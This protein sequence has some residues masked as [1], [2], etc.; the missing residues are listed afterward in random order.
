MK[1]KNSSAKI[2]ALFDLAPDSR[3]SLSNCLAEFFYLKII[4]LLKSETSCTL[5]ITEKSICIQTDISY[6]KI[7]VNKSLIVKLLFVYNS[8]MLSSKFY[9]STFLCFKIISFCVFFLSFLCLR[10]QPPHSLLQLTGT[11]EIHFSSNLFISICTMLSTLSA[12]AVITNIEL[13]KS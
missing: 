6:A 8:L 9:S 2:F 12:S 11:R 13:I 10:N 7:T 4:I 5:Y 1:K 3:K